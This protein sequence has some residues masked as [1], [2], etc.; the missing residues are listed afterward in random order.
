VRIG[1]DVRSLSEPVTGIGR[2]TL[3]LLEEMLLDKSH[4]WV[5]Y[6]HR[7]ILHGKWGMQ[8][9]TIRTLSFPKWVRGLYVPWSQFI[10]PLWVKQDDIDIFWSPAH[11]LP[12]YLPKSIASVVT[13]HDLVWRH[14]PETMK[15]F[16]RFLDAKFMPDAIKIADQVIAVSE[17]TERDLVS[18]IPE[19]KGKVKVIY[20]ANSLDFVDFSKKFDKV[21]GEY[22]LFVGTLEP[23]KNLARLVKAYSML[24]ESLRN[25]FSLV[26]VGGKG[27]GNENLELIIDQLNI[28]KFVKFFGYLSNDE[29]VNVYSNAYLFV[30]PSLYE[31]FGLPLLEAMNF[32]VP[33]VTSNNSSMPEVGGDA[34][35]LVDPNNVVSIKN[36]IESVV[37]NPKVR[38]ELSY[39]GF[40]RSKLFSWNKASKETIDV[41]EKAISSREV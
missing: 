35:I 38:T 36:G 25:K 22:I 41:F 28:K 20:E 24:S 27:W 29:L 17:S 21:D 30:M 4:E 18:E 11:S 31:G 15:S 8:N 23:R 40:E 1:V 12:R 19:A 5:L 32:G 14:A 26:I 33:V 6:S 16:S 37:L 3:S 9:V 39:N 2:Y 34:A 10:L 7:P 13:I